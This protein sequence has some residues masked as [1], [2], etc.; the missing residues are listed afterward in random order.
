[1]KLLWK[2]FGAKK[3]PLEHLKEEIEVI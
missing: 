3:K 2:I 1:M